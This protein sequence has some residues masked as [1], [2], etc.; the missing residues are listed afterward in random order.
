LVVLF[1]FLLGAIVT[2][3]S[4]TYEHKF[5]LII[6][7]LIYPAPAWKEFEE[8][9]GSQ[10]SFS[11][12]FLPTS[13]IGHPV[14]AALNIRGE[15][16]Y[17]LSKYLNAPIVPI[18]ASETSVQKKEPNEGFEQRIIETADWF[19]ATGENLRWDKISALM[20]PYKFH[21]HTYDIQ[22]PWYSG[23][24]QGMAGEVLLAAYYVSKEVKYYNGA[25]MAANGLVIPIHAGGTA[26]V[27]EDGIWFEEY[28]SSQTADHPPLVL[29]GHMFA[30]DLL[31]WLKQIDEATWAPLYLSAHKAV[32]S[33]IP[34]YLSLGWSYYDLH[35]TL[36]NACYHRIHARQLQR[37]MQVAGPASN[38]QAAALSIERR[39]ILPIGIFERLIY[40]HNRMII[41]LWLINSCIV[42]AVILTAGIILWRFKY[43]RE[44]ARTML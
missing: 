10:R 33:Y 25:V 9:I 26:V 19:L 5:A 32:E 4:E 23:M 36:S 21:V 15:V 30:M 1:A 28:A 24:A 8:A 12:R 18:L 2:H 29:N 42:F 22:P 13:V 39:L 3:Y 27:L 38:I 37:L 40:Q 43:T 20:M 14:R 6:R 34:R 17:V 41:F 44:R 7:G 11:G 31:F 16:Y 35:G